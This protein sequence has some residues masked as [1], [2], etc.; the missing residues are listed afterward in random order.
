MPLRLRWFDDQFIDEFVEILVAG[1]GC[2]RSNFGGVES[3]SRFLHRFGKPTEVPAKSESRPA[4]IASCVRVVGAECGN[5][6]RRLTTSKVYDG[7]HG[8]P[9]RAPW[10]PADLLIKL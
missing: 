8:E 4:G 2:G 9:V 3:M 6:K 10:E 5:C 7:C 1:C